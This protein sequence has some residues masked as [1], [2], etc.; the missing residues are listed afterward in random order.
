MST[1]L[2]ALFSDASRYVE[3]T[4]QHGI[5][6]IAPPTANIKE[7]MGLIGFL[8]GRHPNIIALYLGGVEW[9]FWNSI[10]AGTSAKWDT[11][12]P[13]SWLKEHSVG[14]NGHR[15]AQ[16]VEIAKASPAPD[17][18]SIVDRLKRLL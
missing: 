16:I 11:M 9:E 6:A 12:E 1:P 3:E 14:I 7:R 13:V 15:A 8:R 4:K 5:T 2:P 17:S 10:E 18:N